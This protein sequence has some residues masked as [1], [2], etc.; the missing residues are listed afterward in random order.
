[1]GFTQKPDRSYFL[2]I[3]DV[4]FYHQYSNENKSLKHEYSLSKNKEKEPYI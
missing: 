4:G 2:I 1:V 3:I